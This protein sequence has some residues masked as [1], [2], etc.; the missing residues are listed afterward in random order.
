[1]PVTVVVGAQWGDEGKGKVVD[2]IAE[3]ADMVIRFQGGPNAGHTIVNSYGEFKLHG[4]PSGIFRPDILS[5]I[6]PGTVVSPPG[7]LDEIAGVQNRGV[8]TDNLILSDRAHLI[9]PWHLVMEEIEEKSRGDHKIGTTKKAVGPAYGDKYA[10][11][12]LRVG[13]LAH[14]SWLEKRL[15]DILAFRNPWFTAWNQ[16]EM[17]VADLMEICRKWYQALKPYIQDTAPLVEDALKHDRNIVLEGQLGIGKGVDW[18]SYPYVTSSC[19]TAGGASSG[20]GIPPHM[21]KNVLGI[22]KAYST[23]VGAGPMVTLD[24][25][26]I[27]PRL[28][29]LGHE[30]GATTGRPRKCGWLDAVILKH[31]ARI[32]GFTGIAITRVDILDTI[33]SIGICTGYEYQGKI[34]ADMPITPVLEQCKPVYEYMPGWNC[35]TTG[36]RTWE[37]LPEAAKNYVNRISEFTRAP[38]TY[39]SVGPRREE[40]IVM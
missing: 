35:D 30:Y 13:D 3:N 19:P 32:N 26:D 14:E 23:S 39:V 10:R 38:I 24:E 5:I 2:F 11:W 15:T 7:L 40:T 22:V 18:G 17:Q 29:E 4:V 8:N 1:M 27:G 36:I 33:D 9:M 6:G 25:S 12:G 21:I 31:A 37:G 20:A 28:R 16:P 34:L